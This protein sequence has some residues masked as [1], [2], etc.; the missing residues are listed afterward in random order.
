MF[1]QPY[2]TTPLSKLVLDG[3]VKDVSKSMAL[4]ELRLAKTIKG[5]QVEGIFTIPSYVKSVPI[6]AHPL[7]FDYNSQPV[8]VLDTRAYLKE[9]ADGSE[10]IT[11][12]NEYTFL[13]HRAIMSKAWIAG[14]QEQ[15]VDRK[16]FALVVYARWV[17]ELMTRRLGLG[18]L[19]QVQLMGLAAYFYLCQFGRKLDKVSTAQTIALSTRIR[20]DTVHDMIAPLEQSHLIADFVEWIKQTIES[21]RTAMLNPGLV[22][23]TLCSSWYGAAAREVCGVA[24][25]YPP[26]LLSLCYAGLTDRSYRKAPLTK[27]IDQ[28]DYKGAGKQFLFSMNDI[29]TELT[30]D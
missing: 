14:Q 28:V 23:A 15:M 25:E 7:A 2:Q 26:Y 27:L 30:D 3:I 6:F 9:Q 5:R 4:Q 10:K 11:V 13:L 8:I 29:M 17:S 18:A 12:P 20:F 22:Y 16:D 21:P 19:E 1:N 24:L